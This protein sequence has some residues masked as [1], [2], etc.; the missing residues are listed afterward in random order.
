METKYKITIPEPCHEDWNK[1]SPKDNGRFCLSCTKTVV[2]FT[3]MLPEEIQHYFI[4][5]QN[6]KNHMGFV[7]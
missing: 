3:S 6:K 7:R 5:N 4:Q 2:D 1:M